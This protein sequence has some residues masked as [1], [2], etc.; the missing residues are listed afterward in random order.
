MIPFSSF[1]FVSCLESTVTVIAAIAL[2]R[3]TI[4]VYNIRLMKNDLSIAL[5]SNQFYFNKNGV[6]HS[7]DFLVYEY[8]PG[9][10]TVMYS[11]YYQ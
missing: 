7:S 11:Y 10:K 4:R 6:P 3:Q 2:I 9:T 5:Y 8:A 1:C